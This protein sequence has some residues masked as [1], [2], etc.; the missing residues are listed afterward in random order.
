MRTLL[1]RRVVNR[2]KQAGVLLSPGLSD[3]EL[4]EIE[5]RFG[6]QFSNEHRQLLSLALPLGEGWV[7]WRSADPAELTDRLDRPTRGVIFDVKNNAFW[8]T[9]WDERPAERPTATR[10]AQARLTEV[11]QLVPVFA[12]RYLPAGPATRPFPVLS[13]HQTDVIYYGNDLLD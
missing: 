3:R 5:A 4:K 2:L 13:V 8:P 6:F 9:S 12:H 11:P 1:S 10:I 7:E